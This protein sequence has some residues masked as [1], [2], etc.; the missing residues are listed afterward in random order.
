M[1][2]I[3]KVI[4]IILL[5]LII[6]GI[7]FVVFTQTSIFKSWLKSKAI[8]WAQ[9]HLNGQIELSALKGNLFTYFQLEGLA[10]HLENE[11]I[12]RVKRAS[13]HYDLFS[14]LFKKLVFRQIVLEAPELKLIQHD[15]QIWNLAK[16]LKPTGTTG[17]AQDRQNLLKLSWKIELPK[18]Q[19][20]SGAAELKTNK[21]VPWDIPKKV[22]NLEL[23][24]GLWYSE[25]RVKLSLEELGFNTEEPD[26]K[27]Q[28][29]HSKLQLNPDNLEAQDFEIETE[30]SKFTSKLDVKNLRNP[31]LHFLIKGHPISLAEI[32]K[33]VPVLKLYGNPRFDLE[34]QGPLDDL[35]VKCNLWVGRGTIEILG[36]LQVK[37][38]PY[39]YRLR[40]NVA[41]FNLAE[42]TNQPNL[43]SNLNFDFNVQGK[44]IAW[45]KI[46]AQIFCK[47]DSSKAMGKSFKESLL[48][49]DIRG[50]SLN[51]IVDA[52][53]EGASA[54]FSGQFISKIKL[55][56]YQITGKIRDLNLG[57]FFQTERISSD[58]D[59]N[60]NLSGQGWNH[61]SMSGNLTLQCWPSHINQI[62]ID[63]AY[64]DL[65]LRNHKL[66]LNAFTISSPLAKILAEGEISIQ[67]QNH[68]K[69]DANFVDFSVLSK[70]LPIDSL[71]GKGNLSCSFEGP[72]DSLVVGA[73]LDLTGV[74]AVDLDIAQF[75]GDLSGLFSKQ[76]NHFQFEGKASDAT[77]FGIEDIHTNFKI[78]Y[79]DS[80]SQFAFEVQQGDNL[81]VGSQGKFAFD[82]HGYHINLEDLG[83]EYF[84]QNWRKIE[85]ETKIQFLNSEFSISQLVLASEDQSF[86]LFGKLC[87]S[88]NSELTIELANLDIAKL[89]SLF[90]PEPNY[91]GRLNIAAL[92]SGSMEKPSLFG[93][94][95]LSQG[96]YFDVLFDRFSGHFE[97]KNNAF[98]WKCLVSKTES[99]S[100]LESSGFLPVNVSL[101][102]FESELLEDEPLEFK[103]STRGLDLSFLEAFSKNIRNIEGTLVADV[104]LSNTLN[105]LR[106]VGPIRLFHGK[107]DIP[108]LGTKYRDVDLVL[109]LKG[110]ELKINDFR[111]KSGDGDLRIVEGSLSLSEKTLENF[112]AHFKAKNFELMN[113]K[114]MQAIV[115][116]DIKFSGSIQAPVYSGE[117]TV[118]QARIYYPAWLEEDTAVELNERPFFV[119]SSDSVEFDTSGAIRFQ[120]SFKGPE[121]PLSETQLYKSLRGDVSIYFPRNTWIRSQQ[122]NIE[123]EGE[124]VPLKEGP[125]IA[126]F[127]AF[128]AIRGYYE[129]LGNRFQIKEGEL[130]FN[131]ELEPNPEIYIEAVYEFQDLT[132]EDPQKHEIKVLATGTLQFPQFKFT[133]DDQ[134]A[135]QKDILSF[136]L[137]GRSFDDLTLGQRTSVSDDSGLENK[138]TGFITGQVLSRLTSKLGNELR[139]DV[140]QIESGK[141]LADTKV[142][143]GKYITPDVFV[144]VSQDFGA[145]GDRK[146][147]LEYEI[148]KKILFFNLLLQASRERK[149]DTA[150]DVIW[151]I[152]W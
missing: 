152:E 85:P 27:V 127:G 47:F 93:N 3:I 117:L 146:V 83:I 36:N 15:D 103:I 38:P 69:L 50:D 94:V 32:R 101:T 114:K 63:S 44:D 70:A 150:L 68:L 40:G 22:R 115:K 107:F 131:G 65:R 113:N 112:N 61:D 92:F 16:L 80:L 42:I 116:G 135:E 35:D 95:N 120:K 21:T 79:S 5:S 56:I 19:I 91:E 29:I 8:A 145:E 2:K 14:L 28:T 18:V 123:V 138:A 118:T 82:P 111:L 33:A 106:G 49:L 144:S 109:V 43:A 17:E 23:N 67:K 64:F 11:P 34:A 90:E 10:I 39:G 98:F 53:V 9:S 104:V 132:A 96:R 30:S 87:P 88:G 126:L 128:S 78:N 142:R 141:N 130:V 122:A 7:V 48:E 71:W 148:P 149:G 74:G 124:L 100:L 89:G 72:L 52:L 6:L 60:L 105:D 13:L 26:F 24:L 58:F 99:D 81:S 37:A 108:E 137:F 125:E 76:G 133:L 41:N 151:K 54:N 119:I 55:P 147:E 134:E 59:L 86:T 51:F 20:V 1:N 66:N 57:R 139:L 25:G 136:L 97:Y 4:S 129:L 73:S 46:D 62:L 45:G 31:I 143:I 102:P 75:Q 140:I 121:S 77:A 110:K 12:I 84:G